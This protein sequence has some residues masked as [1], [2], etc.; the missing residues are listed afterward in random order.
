M[1]KK[2]PK[3]LLVRFSSIGDIVLTSALVR[4]LHLQ[5]E[6]EIHF[7]TKLSFKSIVAY[8][9]HV[10]KV[11]T[12]DK[13]V[14]EVGALL[15][16]E[17]YDMVIDLHQNIRS[18]IVKFYLLGIPVRRLRKLS[19][20]KWVLSTLKKNWLPDIHIVDRYFET[21]KV[22]GVENDGQG[23]EF[24]IP[25]AEEL[26]PE[27]KEEF[28]I[29]RSDSYLALVTGAA[30]ATKRLPPDRLLALIEALDCPV[31]L[32]GGKE[33]MD[34]ASFIME[35]CE[36]RQEVINLC[37]KL[38]LLQSAAMVRDAAV[39]VTHDTGLMH[40]AAAFKKPIISVW[41]NT[42]PS[43]GMTPYY[44]EGIKKGEIFEVKGLGCRPCSH[45]GYESCPKKHFQCMRGH[46]VEKIAL[47]AK[48]WW[49][50]DS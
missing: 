48:Q 50:A 25:T 9:P 40:V 20:L 36:R 11:V 45:I 34:V 35:N 18:L 38:T 41:G 16:S 1:M 14:N 17:R 21:A 44:P 47:S 23:L 39:V 43:F 24:F 13:K 29:P 28:L 15:K 30:H 4:C 49:R 33:D 26:S 3:I 31:V 27:Q 2:N 19:L 10:S 22:L 8:N 46:S 42:V 12:I 6:A 7:L 37:G 32:L 5:L